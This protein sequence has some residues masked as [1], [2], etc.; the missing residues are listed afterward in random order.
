[1]WSVFAGVVETN[2]T[3]GTEGFDG[4]GRVVVIRRSDGV[5]AMYAHLDRSL[6]AVGE[7]V[8][9]GQ[10]IATVGTSRGTVEEPN[11]QFEISRAHLHFEASRKP[12][13]LPPER[14][15]I[16]PLGVSPMPEPEE[17]QRDS[18]ERW[19]KLNGLIDKLFAA[20]PANRRAEVQPMLTEWRAAYEAAPRMGKGL[21]A[22]AI[23]DWVERYNKAR[24][25]LAQAGATVPPA[26]RD[27]GLHEDAADAAEAVKD[28]AMSAGSF[29]LVAA[30]AYLWWQSQQRE[31]VI[32]IEMGQA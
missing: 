29:V 7:Q 26:V 18:I 30:L 23:S 16:D 2:A 11:K 25:V 28:A 20:V 22:A 27:V 4:Y 1:V 19:H 21:R 12:Y 15:R 24:G 3:P 17:D 5:R 14:D 6:V 8:T 10:Q 9:E 13:P 32:H 31:Q